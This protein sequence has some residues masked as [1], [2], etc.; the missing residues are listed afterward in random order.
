MGKLRVTPGMESGITDHVSPE[1][2]K[3]RADYLLR[4]VR[5]GNNRTDCSL[6]VLDGGETTQKPL[7]ARVVVRQ[8]D[9]DPVR[10]GSV[11]ETDHNSHFQS[12]RCRC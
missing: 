3:W 10:E 12:R 7:Y 2:R 8:P 5:W 9:C 4:V 1:R 11:H 6:P